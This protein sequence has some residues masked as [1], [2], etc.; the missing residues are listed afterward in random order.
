M[1]ISVVIPTYNMASYL[2][3]SLRSLSYQQLGEG[4]ELEVVVVDDGSSDNTR[5]VV[6]DFRTTTFSLIY[7]FIPRG[8]KSSRS[9][10]RN[11]GIQRTTGE[12]IVLLDSG[13]LISPTFVLDAARLIVDDE[14]RVIVHP[15]VGIVT[16]HD[17]DL[18]EIRDLSPNTF[19]ELC[20]R[21]E[22]LP[23]WR[24]PRSGYFDLVNGQINRLAAPW[25]FVWACALS[26]H[27]SL[28][29]RS[30][31]FDETFVAW[32]AEDIELGM[33]LLRAGAVLVADSQPRALHIPHPRSD[34][35]A[36]VNDQGNLNLL[37]E[38]HGTRETEL[39]RYYRG[40]VINDVLERFDKL[41]TS[42][43]GPSYSSEVLRRLNGSLSHADRT[44]L[45]AGDNHE[46]AHA[47]PA[48]HM[49]VHNE[50]AA[51]RQRRLF[52][53][54]VVQCL[55][56]VDT[57]FEDGYFET[58]IATDFARM[59][60]KTLIDRML[61]ELVRISRN[62]FFVFQPA[63]VSRLKVDDYPWL[64]VEEIQNI[65]G[66]RKLALSLEDTVG[67]FQVFRLKVQH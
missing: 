3:Q 29:I 4:S 14:K 57:R 17:S 50:G 33:R 6:S 53:T 49:L 64:S 30:G 52:P 20:D 23:A 12:L 61:V 65:C 26:M 40:L 31:A 7:E 32:G 41:V 54:R 45:I 10:T 8:P 19:V 37:H 36:K 59:L 56:G 28:L 22:S 27:K 16:K 34:A 48:T 2:L 67:P 47:L 1:K 60:S 5:D 24:D 62:T 15:C 39:H 63:F 18:S 25:K 51:A 35:P 43:A 42:Y 9:A 66:E 46:V 11:R 13:V 58:A 21:L 44:L 55:I 38:L